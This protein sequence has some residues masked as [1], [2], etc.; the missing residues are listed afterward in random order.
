MGGTAV[1]WPQPCNDRDSGARCSSQ[2]LGRGGKE[3]LDNDEDFKALSHLLSALPMVEGAT[4]P[5]S[6]VIKV[7]NTG[8]VS[9]E[10]EALCAVA[11]AACRWVHQHV[12]AL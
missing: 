6:V 3:A 10:V 4:R 2:G 1:A 12:N 5:N 9:A 8:E 11:C 7:V